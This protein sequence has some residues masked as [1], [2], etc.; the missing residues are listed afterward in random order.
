MVVVASYLFLTV[1]RDSVRRDT[2]DFRV[3]G[4]ILSFRL[5]FRVI[6]LDL[7]I[8]AQNSSAMT[9][10]QGAEIP[11]GRARSKTMHSS[12]HKSSK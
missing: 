6:G 8:D 12:H 1:R 7:G 2:K 5:V 10:S 11:G 4:V 9:S 3:L